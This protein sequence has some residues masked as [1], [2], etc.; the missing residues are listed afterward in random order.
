[1]EPYTKAYHYGVDKFSGHF[2][3]VEPIPGWSYQEIKD[4]LEQPYPDNDVVFVKSHPF[5]MPPKTH[6]QYIPEGFV[7]T[8]IIRHPAKTIRSLYKVFVDNAHNPDFKYFDNV[9]ED[10]G[11]RE[12]YEMFKLVTDTFGQSPIVVDYDDLLANPEVTL[13]KYCDAVGIEYTDKMIHWEHPPPNMED[14]GKIGLIW[15][16]DVL[17]STGFYKPSQVKYVEK[18]KGLVLPVHIQKEIEICTDYYNE[19]YEYK[20]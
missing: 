20:L 12:L 13:R 16:K 14:Y 19:V 18:H 3:D 17:N 10:I 7:H 5:T 9:S 2:D 15:F 4:R 11:V 8:F 6:W 1:M